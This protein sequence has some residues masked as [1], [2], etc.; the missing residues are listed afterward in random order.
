MKR[1]SN[2]SSVVG[3]SVVTHTEL[4][5]KTAFNSLIICI[6]NVQLIKTAILSSLSFCIIK[7]NQ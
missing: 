5:S 2:K 4:T 6:S 3:V 7:T 1:T